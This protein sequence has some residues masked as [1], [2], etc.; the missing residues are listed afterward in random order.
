MTPQQTQ[1]LRPKPPRKSRWLIAYPRA[2]PLAIFVLV[3]AITALSIYTI[4]RSEQQEK[5]AELS[6]TAQAV[7]SALERRSYAVSAYLRSGAALFSTLDEVSPVMFRRFVGE[8]QR[9]AGNRGSE[10]IG[11]A[12]AIEGS[13]VQE[14]QIRIGDSLG[15]R[16]RVFPVPETKSQRVVPVTFLYPLISRNAQAVGYDMYS[17][18]RR[19]SAMET[20]IREA[21]P[22]VS[23]PVRLLQDEGANTAG[24]I[25]YMPVFDRSRANKN[26]RGFIYSPFNGAVFLSSAVERESADGTAF[27]LYDGR[28]ST[29]TLV[30]EVAG[31]FPSG[32]VVNEEIN[33]AN[34]TMVLQAEMAAGNDLSMLSLL[35][36]L[37][38]LMVGSLL[39]LVARLLTQ[40]A[41]EDQARLDFFEQ[42]HSIRNLLTRELNHRV[43]NTLAN[44]LSI[45]HLTRRRAD[46]LDDFAD[47]LDG[48]IR[49]LSATHD[50]LTRSDWGATPLCDV[51]AAELSPYSGAHGEGEAS[52]VEACGPPVELAPNDALSLG[53]A[54]HELAT[55]AAKYGALSTQAGRVRVAW[56]KAGDKL[57]RIDWKESGGPEVTAEPKRGFGTDLIEKIVAHELRH[58]VDLR[59]DPAGVTCSLLVPVR[60]RQDFNIRARKS[61][62]NAED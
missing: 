35:T 42:Q 43:K 26:L 1:V 9:D 51:V 10:G 54:I 7:G 23:A 21:K 55:N 20:A 31:D 36:A 50:L 13:G 2:L 19:S 48:R 15:S 33:V 41:M 27:R 29:D 25:M 44:V 49:A 14:F 8:L 32:A 39:T 40:Q 46:T 24:F 11:W 56:S 22:I 5:R 16:V 60:N 57:A 3:A 45:I 62:G 18:E 4:E 34:R 30:A 47:A 59:F 52:A 61:E 17:D 58:P 28:I 6:E 37:F 12:E 53:L 38:G